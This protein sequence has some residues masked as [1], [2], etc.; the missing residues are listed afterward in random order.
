MRINSAKFV[1][2]LE[3]LESV[4]AQL[5]GKFLQ[6]HEIVE[7][8]FHGKAQVLPNKCPIDAFLVGLDN[9]ISYLMISF[10]SRSYELY[11]TGFLLRRD[12]LS[13]RGV[14]GQRVHFQ[15]RF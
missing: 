1:I 14:W 3:R 13:L 6:P 10:R 2:M 4:L 5:L 8:L 7:S 15:R 9:W 12:F 11:P